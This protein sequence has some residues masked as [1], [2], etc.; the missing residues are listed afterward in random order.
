MNYTFLPQITQITQINL[1]NPRNLW[2]KITTKSLPL[3]ITGNMAKSIRMKL[4]FI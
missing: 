4:F 3:V 1:C 2:L